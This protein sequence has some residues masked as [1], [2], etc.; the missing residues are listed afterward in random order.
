MS[1][2]DAETRENTDF[3]L[4][5]RTFLKGAGVAGAAAV[6]GPS[7]ASSALQPAAAQTSG[8]VGYGFSGSST[9]RTSSLMMMTV[10]ITPVAGGVGAASEAGGAMA[11][12][13]FSSVSEQDL[14]EQL[15]LSMYSQARTIQSNWE[16]LTK[17]WYNNRQNAQNVAIAKAKYAAGKEID[18]G[19][20]TASSTGLACRRAVL[21]QAGI[22]DENMARILE[23]AMA[24]L[25]HIRDRELQSQTM[26][27]PTLWYNVNDDP[28]N[29]QNEDLIEL[30]DIELRLIDG[31]EITS[32]AIQIGRQHSDS[33]EDAYVHPWFALSDDEYSEYVV[34]RDDLTS[35]G[36]TGTIAKLGPERNNL[37]ADWDGL[38]VEEYDSNNPRFT[39]IAITHI[40]GYDAYTGIDDFLREFHQEWITLADDAQQMG[41]DI[42]EAYNADQI[43][44]NDIIDPY[45]RATEMAVD[46]KDTGHHGYAAGFANQLGYA[47]D[48]S[49]TMVVDWYDQSA[50]ETTELSGTLLPSPRVSTESVTK[51]ADITGWTYDANLDV[52]AGLGGS[53]EN[54]PTGE[55]IL[56]QRTGHTVTWT[57]SS[58]TTSTLSEGSDY[59]DKLGKGA[60]EVLSSGSVG[61]EEGT[62]TVEVTSELLRRKSFSTGST[63]TVQSDGD[64]L[65]A[66]QGGLR[67][68]DSGDEFTVKKLYN[69][70]GDEIDEVT[71]DPGNVQTLNTQQILDRLEA[72]EEAQKDLAESDPPGGG[73]GGGNIDLPSIG[74]TDLVTFVEQNWPI[75]GG[76]AVAGLVGIQVVTGALGK[77]IDIYLPW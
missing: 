43:D 70:S 31:R 10:P 65:F 55:E 24:R 77:I 68:F 5:R 57:D 39:P 20:A 6:A 23:S 9:S 76:I 7:A 25:Q 74:G 13:L 22:L 75:L 8:G 11:D 19:G 1:S 64:Y 4:D 36:N 34:N 49:K 62:I 40:E 54:A 37:S 63:Y 45:A 12:W 15:E 30:Q 52:Q 69:A 28:D 42:Y 46:W 3:D 61:A 72:I 32:K 29:I 48:L 2:K 71:T 35:D 66:V 17:I 56:A 33:S 16:Q 26:D 67:T 51:T 18:E 50:N 27:S 60:I 59:T 47:S 38:I 58:G 53:T 21:E 14:E 41:E 44:L 73:G